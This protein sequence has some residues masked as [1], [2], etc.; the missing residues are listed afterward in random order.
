MG[1][2]IE[3]GISSGKEEWLL[4]SHNAILTRCP[5]SFDDIPPDKGLI[6]VVDNYIFEAAAYCFSESELKAF[7]DLSDHRPKKW[8]LVDK[9]VAE[10]LSGYKT[11]DT[12]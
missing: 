3:M 8:L 4:K 12:L 2:Y 11:R 10:T 5:D 1:F 9:G 7:S 6:C